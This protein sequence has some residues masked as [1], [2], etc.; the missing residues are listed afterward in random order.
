M[1]H[2]IISLRDHG[3]MASKRLMDVSKERLTTTRRGEMSRDTRR[4]EN[5]TKWSETDLQRHSSFRSFKPEQEQFF[6]SSSADV[7]ARAFCL[8]PFRQTKQIT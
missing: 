5:E 3:T 7:V 2:K 6:S 1:V 8:R 4:K